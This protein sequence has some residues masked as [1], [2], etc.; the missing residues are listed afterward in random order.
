MSSISFGLTWTRL[1][2]GFGT[3]GIALSVAAACS[4]SGRRSDSLSTSFPKRSKCRARVF[5]SVDMSGTLSL[6]F[7]YGAIGRLDRSATNSTDLQHVFHRR[8]EDKIRHLCA[9]ATV[10]QDEDAWLF[11]S[12]L[13]L[14]ITQQVEHLRIIAAAKLSGKAEFVERRKPNPTR[15]ETPRTMLEKKPLPR[16]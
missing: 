3:L 10:A 4:V 7:P 15:F 11:L 14:L 12:E 16:S 13:R 8:L 9:L 2:A 6:C 5:A 1:N